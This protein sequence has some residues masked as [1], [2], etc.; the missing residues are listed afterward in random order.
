[1]ATSI[2]S[3]QGGIRSK[4][5]QLEGKHALITGAGSGIGRALAIEAA[6][7]GMTVALCGRRGEALNA[8]LA[9]MMPG[10]THLRLRGDITDPAV[11]RGL[12]DYLWQHWGRLDVL[13]NN[14][15]IVAAGPLANT[16]D[17]G[18]ERMMMTNVVAPIA[19]S[20][21]MMP[22][23]RFAAPSRIVNV[24]SI[25]GDIAYPLFAPYSASKFALR[26]LSMAMRRE[27]KPYGI[28]VTYVAPRATKT[29]PTKAFED[30]VE[31]L[32]M[33]MD[34]PA[35]AAGQIWRAVAKDLDTAYAKGAERLFLLI[36]KFAPN[37][38]DRA[39]AAQMADPR[40]RNYLG[41]H[42]PAARQ[43]AG[44]HRG[45][46]QRASE[47]CFI[48]TRSDAGAGLNSRQVGG[49]DAQRRAQPSDS[50]GEAEG[51]WVGTAAEVE[52]SCPQDGG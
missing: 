5:M 12:Q 25:F 28:G 14:A 33:R 7:R 36:Q 47:N 35:C 49:G 24:G 30:L 20:R 19:L 52:S 51:E 2:T 39:I 48:D 34:D 42:H 44:D 31:P 37:I 13:V 29:D 50:G 16:T 46:Q 23:L 1:M 27:F 40:I 38:V 6:R 10:K 32:Q 22:L 8:T 21:E 45:D 18:L 3:S 43:E 26:G 4:A 41:K 15:G 11:R 17:A 9:L